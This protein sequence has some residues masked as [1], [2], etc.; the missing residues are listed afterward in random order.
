MSRDERSFDE[1]R[2]AQGRSLMQAVREAVASIEDVE[3][4]LAGAV[5]TSPTLDD[6]V[7]GFV[8]RR[9][10]SAIHPGQ[11]AGCPAVVGEPH[12]VGCPRDVF[13]QNLNTVRAR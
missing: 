13:Q 5:R 4:A 10:E 9:D 12:N 6:G 11:C 1:V 3:E 2:R 7:C 8:S